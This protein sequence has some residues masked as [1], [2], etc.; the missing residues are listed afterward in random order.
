MNSLFKPNESTTSI[1]IES[2]N[3]NQEDYS[4]LDIERNLQDWT[5]PDV[6]KNQIYKISTF[7]SKFSFLTNYTIKTV[8]KTIS[9]NNDYESL[10]LLTKKAIDQ[11]KK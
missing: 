7:S 9:L 11:H 6:P 4:I 10:H 2:D 5:I 1:P 8:E 3:I